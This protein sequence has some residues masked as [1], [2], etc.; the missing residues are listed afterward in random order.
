MGEN[1]CRF[2]SDS[3]K[4]TGGSM[5]RRAAVR[6]I[7]T[8]EQQQKL[9]QLVR[10]H[11]TSQKLVERAKMI[12]LAAEGYNVG[13]TAQ[14]LGVWRKTVSEWRK[15]WLAADARTG[16]TERLSDAPRSGAPATFTPEN[17]CA[18]MAVA[19]ENLQA[20]G[21]P[22][23][24]WTHSEL[25]REVLSRGIVSEISPRSVGRFLKKRRISSLT[26]CGGG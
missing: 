23:S 25:T 11:S 13:S 18:I 15:R 14:Q 7:L 24:H 9:E 5:S 21:Q 2:L 17:I 8:Q 12:L 19:C 26:A 3:L 4:D 6:I 10:A 16:V 22:I 20:S 1:N